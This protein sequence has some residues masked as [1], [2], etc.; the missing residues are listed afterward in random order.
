MRDL[1]VLFEV[2]AIIVVTWLLLGWSFDRAITQGDGT[3]FGVPYV[4]SALHAGVD[5]SRHLYRFGVVGGAPMHDL[6]GSLPLVQFCALLGLSATTTANLTTVFLQLCFAFFGIKGAQAL[7][8]SWRSEP[9][10]PSGPERIA[11]IW[12]CG[13]APVL[14][15]RLAVGHENLLF[16]LLPFA[17][18]ISLLF[19]ARAG[20]L[21]RTTLVFGAI[22]TFHGVSSFGSQML[23][24]SAVFGLP[25]AIAAVFAERPR[26]SR[27][28]TTVVCAVFAGLLLA[29][30]RMI[31]MVSYALSDDA[32][33]SV[34]DVVTYSFGIATWDD[35]ARSI[36][37]TIG[38]QSPIA[39]HEQNYSFGPVLFVA[40][41]M[42]PH[43][44]SKRWW[45]AIGMSALLAVLFAGAV[46]PISTVLLDAI[47]P[48]RAFRVPARAIL[49]LLV[50]IPTFALAAIW[51]LRVGTS[52]A[53]NRYKFAWL[54]V[55]VGALVIAS[56]HGRLPIAREILV[57][58]GCVGAVAIR[59]RPTRLDTHAFTAMIAVIAGLGVAAFDERFPRSIP[60]DPIEHGPRKLREAVLA[61]QPELAMPLNRVQIVDAQPYD[62]GTAFAAQLSSLD[63]DF[64]PP[65]RFLE[66]LG[67]LRGKRV[68][69]TTVVFRLTRSSMFP[70]LQQLYNVRAVVRVGSTNGTIEE[71]PDTPGPAWFPQRIDV[72][73]DAASMATVLRAHPTDLRAT[74]AGTAWLLRDDLARVHDLPLR[75]DGAR[76]GRVVTDE[77]GQTATIDVSLE[78]ACVLVVATNYV[79]TLRATARVDG[80]ARE[81]PTLP[82]DVALT[83]VVVPARATSLTL[84][85][86]E[87]VP[88]W[89]RIAQLLGL[90]L[91]LGATVAT[92]RVP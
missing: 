2:A 90:V 91:L 8:S 71:L 21:S 10:S 49:P 32:S 56:L 25:I 28:H 63:G 40:I 41:A 73:A 9:Y 48:L 38:V 14:G 34:R 61:S 67:A 76:V 11:S 7:A 81:T 50:L 24:Y 65:R 13:F 57:W 58:I 70:F 12:L 23:I 53:P 92:R 18:G 82:I 26:W 66:L 46:A 72:V 3:I 5:W 89:T 55:V 54:G 22:A 37:W 80:V 84:A 17:A 4:Q 39:L 15:W 35:W 31:G 60:F 85:P 52:A 6:A 62:V 51:T 43:H 33:R 20:T 88:L 1:R 86:R 16:G 69:P 77:L 59:W 42:W 45:W 19:A 44:A 47:P 74:I 75:C 78:S 64:N 29:L 83:G 36:P 79:S 30:P 27:S 87:P 68:P